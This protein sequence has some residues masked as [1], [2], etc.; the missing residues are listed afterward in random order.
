[1]AAAASTGT[2]LALAS[3]RTSYP[4]S[5]L[6]TDHNEQVTASSLE[7]GTP[8]LFFYPY[9][10]TPCFLIDLDI[11]T[12]AG[13]SNLQDQTGEAYKWLGG[14]GPKRSIVAYSAICAHKM[15]HPAKEI[16]FI[17][18]R[19]DPVTFYNKAGKTEQRQRV[20]SCCSERS[21]YDPV[22]G[23]RVLA[24]PAPQPLA[25]IELAYESDTG[26][27]S[28]TASYGGDMY[29][30][31]FEKFGFRAAIEHKVGDPAAWVGDK[32]KIRKLSEYTGQ[33]IKC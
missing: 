14:V 25:A 11:E 4:A 5:I 1:M 13:S 22:D 15:S 24:G 2:P 19:H 8:Y 27:L 21:V 3:E 12:R 23:A 7:P 33:I 18:Y 28:A 10:S 30:R 17:N 26:A 31:F 20:I 9:I 29:H 6:H 32:T 16:S